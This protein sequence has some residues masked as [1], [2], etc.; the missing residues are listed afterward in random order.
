MRFPLPSSFPS[1][2]E[3][4]SERRRTCAFGRGKERDKESVCEVLLRD[5]VRACRREK[6]VR[7]RA[8]A[9]W[10]TTTSENVSLPS[11]RRQA[12]P[13]ENLFSGYSHNLSALRSIS[14]RTTP[15]KFALPVTR[16]HDVSW[17]L[18]ILISRFFEWS[19]YFF[20]FSKF[21]KRFFI[22]EWER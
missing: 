14:N 6:S 18:G 15:L 2:F 21:L 17:Y 4:G 5:C 11:S 13:R 10:T 9:A 22:S 19:S 12:L 8:C 20:F 3:K 1:P 7:A 16:W